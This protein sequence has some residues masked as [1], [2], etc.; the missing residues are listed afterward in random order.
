MDIT[1]L[2]KES[3]KTITAYGDGGF[4]INGLPYKS[5]LIVFAT[6]V[7]EIALHDFSQAELSHF[8]AII[9]QRCPVEILLIGTGRNVI[10]L[11]ASIRQH[12]KQAGLSVDVMDTGAACRTYNVLLAEDRRVAAF[13]VAVE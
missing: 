8:E 1:P 3:F 12:L 11:P 10:Q 2:M 4:K 6:E 7:V 9:S 5:S 13:L